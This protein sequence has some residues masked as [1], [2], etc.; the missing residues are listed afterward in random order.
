MKLIDT[1]SMEGTLYEPGKRTEGVWLRQGLGLMMDSKNIAQEDWRKYNEP[2]RANDWQVILV[3]EGSYTSRYNLLDVERTKGQLII[4]RPGLLITHTKASSDV[5]LRTLSINPEL[6]GNITMQDYY[7]LFRLTEE[8]RKCVLSYFDLMEQQVKNYN[9]DVRIL[10]DLGSSLLRYALQIGQ[11]SFGKKEKQSQET[12][13]RNTLIFREFISLLNTH[14]TKEHKIAF[15]A[16]QLAMTPNY[17]NSL[18]KQVSGQ[19]IMSWINEYLIAE[20]KATLSHS[21][22]SVENI[23]DALYF[24]NSAFFCKF[25]KK[26]TGLTPSQY[27]KSK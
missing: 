9:L 11:E 8:Q 10:S 21:D 17:L 3:L 16:D 24:P 7:L 15:Y 23:S 2:Y 19:T 13:S 25:F 12:V 20:I 1:I 6:L 14:G 4:Q 27:R 5:N 22:M 26:H 18:I